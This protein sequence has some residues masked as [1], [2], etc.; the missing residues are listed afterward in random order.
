[1]GTINNENFF[2]Y[3]LY[4]PQVVIK[5]VR[6]YYC[7]IQQIIKSIPWCFICSTWGLNEVKCILYEIN[8]N[9]IFNVEVMFNGFFF[10]QTIKKRERK[11]IV[12]MEKF[13]L[14]MLTRIYKMNISWV[15]C[16]VDL[17]HFYWFGRCILIC[18]NSTCVTLILLFIFL[19]Q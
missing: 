6:S 1:M 3:I 8:W 7:S 12:K 10:F 16:F 13:E 11:L 18:G 17:Q 19:N 5:I 2:R 4:I 14:N 15:L 9:V